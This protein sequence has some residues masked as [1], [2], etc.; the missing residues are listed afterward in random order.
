MTVVT[1]GF[2]QIVKGEFT[3]IVG[4]PDTGDAVVMNDTLGPT[5]MQNLTLEN[6][7]VVKQI[8]AEQICEKLGCAGVI[9][10]NSKLI[11][12]YEDGRLEI[13]DPAHNFDKIHVTTTNYTD[14]DY[15]FD[16]FDTLDIID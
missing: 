10:D 16:D 6:P 4:V 11:T 2:I 14:Y 15:C 9:I 3:P 5:L 8:A 7:S 13:L 12:I 1:C